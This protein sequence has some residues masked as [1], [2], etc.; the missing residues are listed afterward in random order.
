MLKCRVV[1]IFLDSNYEN[2]GAF[3][4]KGDVQLNKLRWLV[5]FFPSR[6]DDS[7]QI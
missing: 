3:A 6:A 2:L 1:D 4:G 5:D 7:G